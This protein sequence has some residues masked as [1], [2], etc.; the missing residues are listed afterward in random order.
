LTF[1][2]DR[3]DVARLHRELGELEDQAASTGWA[4]AAALSLRVDSLLVRLEDGR[5]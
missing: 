2:S 1:R 4:W 5:A 3:P